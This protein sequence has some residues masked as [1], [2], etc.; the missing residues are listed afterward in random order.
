MDEERQRSLKSHP[1]S[2][3]LFARAKATL[4]AG[5]PM[6][7]MTQW[8]GPYPVFLAEAEGARFVD[9]DGNSYVD[10][11]LGDTGAMT[12]HAPKPAVAALADQ[13]ARGITL[14]LPVEDWVGEELARRFGLPHWQF[15][16]TATDANRFTI[17]L[18]REITGRT[19][20]PRVRLVLHG[21]V[22]ETFIVLEDGRP[23]SRPGNVGPPVDPTATTRVVEWNDLEALERELEHGDVAC[24]LAEPAMTN[25]GIILPEQGYHDAL[26]E[27]T[28]RHGTLLV[29]DET[30]TI[31]SGPGGCTR[32]HGLAPDFVT[33][34]KPLASGVPA[35]A[36]GMTDR[37]AQTL[38]A[39]PSVVETSDVGGIGGTLSGNALSLAAMRATLEHVLT[40]EA[41]THMIRLAELFEEGVRG[42][43][44]AFGVPWYVARLGCR[45][46]YKFRP[47]P[48][49]NGS[50]AAAAEDA[51][52]DRFLHLFALNRGV[53]MTP[54]HNMALMSPATGE[55]DVGRHTEVFQEAVS[56]L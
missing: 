13:A 4:L 18:A 50:E 45:V 6:P 55:A 36:Y 52:L 3:E 20:D 42:V 27:I 15:C 25:I 46:E 39:H 7:W 31:C 53:L 54:F 33:I 14:M 24:V 29:M 47:T 11:C 21:T 44:E 34:G 56:L 35:A 32:A 19:E 38:L 41:F 17:R 9:V 22:D 8:A 12:G 43:I 48:P 37:V 49:R 51:D 16:L 10:F 23:R 26:R 5:V 1:R 40:E 2:A 28:R 30:H